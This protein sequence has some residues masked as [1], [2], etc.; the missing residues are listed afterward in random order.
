LLV[1]WFRFLRLARRMRWGKF[2]LGRDHVLQNRNLIRRY[3][4]A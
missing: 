3:G 1:Q 4:G 2:L